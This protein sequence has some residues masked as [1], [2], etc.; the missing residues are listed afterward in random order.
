MD[1]EFLIRVVLGVDLIVELDHVKIDHVSH[2]LVYSDVTSILVVFVLEVGSLRS[3]TEE[4]IGDFRPDSFGE[5]D[6]PFL[7]GS[8]IHGLV[9]FPVN[10]ASI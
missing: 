3:M 7:S 1:K 8:C 4:M 2:F 9:V 10:I 6:D 5:L